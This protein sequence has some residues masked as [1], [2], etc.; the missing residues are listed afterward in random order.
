M[1]VPAEL[2][3]VTPYVRRGEELEASASSASVDPELFGGADSNQLRMAAHYCR[4]YVCQLAME[5]RKQ[6][7]SDSITTFLMSLL[8]RLEDEKKMIPGVS[9]EAGHVAVEM[10]ADALFSR[11]DAQDRAGEHSIQTARDFY[12][13][14]NFF[15]VLTYFGELPLEQQD[16]KKYAKFKAADINQCLKEGRSPQAGGFTSAAPASNTC[17]GGGSGTGGGAHVNFAASAPAF[18]P[19]NA[20]LTP[21]SPPNT[22][23]SPPVVAAA[24]PSFVPAFIPPPTAYPVS[25]IPSPPLYSA[26]MTHSQQQQ[27]QQVPSPPQPQHVYSPHPSSPTFQPLPPPAMTSPTFAAGGGSAQGSREAAISDAIEYAQFAVAA[28]KHNE[29]RLGAD[30][31][32]AA[33]RSLQSFL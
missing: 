10:I 16:K 4:H 9:E 21:S 7:N 18:S 17:A 27:M 30:R 19:D 12:T 20:S 5:A 31:L 24:P 1:Q 28:L 8:T 25:S 32:Q 14:S 2:K 22:L 6:K 3:A 15:D 26:V 11:A 23:A 29:P 33:L 13:A